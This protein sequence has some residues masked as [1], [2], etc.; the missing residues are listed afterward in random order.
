MLRQLC[1]RTF[2]WRGQQ[3]WPPLPVRSMAGWEAAYADA[4]A[5]TEV[6]GT[7]P[8]LPDV[9]A[10]RTWLIDLIHTLVER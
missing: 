8:I 6:D 2:D 3:I 1:M 7:T 4:R 9:A 5:E 10:A